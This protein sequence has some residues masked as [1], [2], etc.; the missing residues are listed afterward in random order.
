MNAQKRTVFILVIFL[1]SVEMYP[2][3]YL[4]EGTE[5][6][7]KPGTTLH[8][9]T[10]I[11]SINANILNYGSID[12]KGNLVNNTGNLFDAN[13]TG[14]LRFAGAAAQEISGDYDAGFYG[15]TEI[16]NTHG[17]ALTSSSSG[18]DQTINGELKLT[19]GKLTLN[20]FNLMLGTVEPTGFSPDK[21]L[22]TNNT[23]MLKRNVP[24]DGVTMVYYPVGNTSY[25]PV[26]L[27]NIITAT[28][29]TYG[30][31]V[32]DQEPA[33]LSSPHLSTEAG[34]LLKMCQMV[35]V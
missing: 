6:F 33:G 10:S 15:I 7:V 9:A 20:E 25:N 23:G 30:V 31:R 5:L 12:L 2:Q 34:L 32:E 26:F 22:V 3:L 19:S 14:T 28:T 13:S 16:D 21:Y 18:S 1:S 29:D 4:I 27:K 11:K 8:A 17:V 35:Q 24:A